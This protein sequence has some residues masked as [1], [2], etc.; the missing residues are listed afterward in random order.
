MDESAKPE[1]KSK[2]K[3]LVIGLSMQVYNLH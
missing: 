1:K 3:V 2:I